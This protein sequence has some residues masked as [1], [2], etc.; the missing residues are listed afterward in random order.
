MTTSVPNTP[1]E[2]VQQNN[3][4]SPEDIW[5]RVKDLKPSELHI[6]T[7]NCLSRMKQYHEFVVEH[8]LNS[9]DESERDNIV[10]WTKDLT[11]LS[12]ILDNFGQLTD[13]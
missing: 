4:C 2:L 3:V 10:I 8:K 12:M 13:D 11:I 6:F 1:N 9:E 5:E 7:W